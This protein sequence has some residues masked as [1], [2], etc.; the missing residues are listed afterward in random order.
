MVP[1]GPALMLFLLSLP[2]IFAPLCYC[3]FLIWVFQ[4]LFSAM[5]IQSGRK[6]TIYFLWGF[7]Y[8]F[9]HAIM[10]FATSLAIFLFLLH[11]MPA[12]RFHLRILR[13]CCIFVLVFWGCIHG[14]PFYFVFLSS[15]L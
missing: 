2:N 9:Y 5:G 4:G 3:V 1:H 15:I 13:S 7:G 10:M 8:P 12:L 11:Y 14:S 6:D